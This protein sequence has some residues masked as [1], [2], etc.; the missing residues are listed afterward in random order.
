MIDNCREWGWRRQWKYWIFDGCSKAI[1]IYLF[2]CYLIPHASFEIKDL[3]KESN[4]VM[5]IPSLQLV[6]GEAEIEVW[7]FFSLL[8]F[9]SCSNFPSIE[10]FQWFIL[11]K[12]CIIIFRP[13]LT[14]FLIFEQYL[15]TL[16]N[17]GISSS[18]IIKT[19]TDCLLW[20]LLE[21]IICGS[22]GIET[23][24]NKIQQRKDK[25]TSAA[26]K[27][28]IFSIPLLGQFQQRNYQ[29]IY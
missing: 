18:L 29:P 17:N 7:P 15:K 9:D 6:N 21:F 28:S 4:R 16:V 10:T 1:I 25:N 27:A 11:S 14:Y 19:F 20:L 23:R 26:K 5:N 2:D 8:M 22:V 24:L 13:L 12:K 3:F